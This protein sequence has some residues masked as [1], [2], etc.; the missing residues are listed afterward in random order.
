MRI[1]T[2]R[3]MIAEFEESMAESTHKN[4]LDEDNRRF[5]PDEVFETVEEAKETIAFL[6][7][8]YKTE[9]G[10]LVYPVL[11][12]NGVHIGH[13]QLVPMENAL[14]EVGYHIAKDY[15]NKGYATE[16]MKAFLG[17][18]MQKKQ[19]DKVYGICVAENTASRKVMEKLG[20]LLEFDGMGEYQGENKAIVKYVY[21]KD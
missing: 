12:K 6:M 13:V 17:E 19:L 9:D 8:V 21:T 2:E 3:I 7:N 5:L 10:P 20:F 15:T 4:S 16:A 1:E 11:L 14:F 18:I